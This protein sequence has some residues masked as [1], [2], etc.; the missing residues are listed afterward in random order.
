MAAAVTCPSTAGRVR[1]LRSRSLYEL[2]TIPM[3][4]KLQHQ[5]YTST[6]TYRTGYPYDTYTTARP[7]QRKGSAA[8]SGDIPSPPVPAIWHRAHRPPDLA[9][10]SP[11]RAAYGVFQ[12]IRPDTLCCTHQ[13]TG[14]AMT[15]MSLLLV[16]ALRGTVDLEGSHREVLLQSSAIGILTT[17]NGGRSRQVEPSDRTDACWG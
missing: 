5:P 8:H 13:G 6:P 4:P 3:L 11:C 12:R 15:R 7:T 16:H 14:V 17:A 2:P 9:G 10:P 1:G